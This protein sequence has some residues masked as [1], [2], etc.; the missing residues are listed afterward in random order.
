MCPH[1]GIEVRVFSFL[2][3]AVVVLRAAND[4]DGDRSFFGDWVMFPQ[5][6]LLQQRGCGLLFPPW[7]SP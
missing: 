1:I 5:P 3:F 7:V 4:A 6:F 2:L